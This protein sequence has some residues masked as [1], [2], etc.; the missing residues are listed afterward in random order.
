MVFVS[1]SHKH[2]GVAI[3]IF[4]AALAYGQRGN[5]SIEGRISDESN[6]FGLE[7]A[8]VTIDADP[9]TPGV[10]ALAEADAFGFY[11]LE[12]LLPGDYQLEFSHP[13]F[14]TLTISNFIVGEDDRTQNAALMPLDAGAPWFDVYIQVNSVVSGI[15]AEGVP[16]R[17]VFDPE[18]AP[19]ARTFTAVT[20]E[21]GCAAFRGVSNGEFQFFFN[22]A[23]A[24]AAAGVPVSP[25]FK[26]FASEPQMLTRPHTVSLFLEPEKDT[27]RFFVDW[28]LFVGSFNVNDPQ[29]AKNFTIKITGVDP[30]DPTRELLPTQ[31]GLTDENGEA[32]F[33]NLPKLAWRVEVSRIGFEMQEG[34]VIIMPEASGNLPDGIQVIRMRNDE[35]LWAQIGHDL[36]VPY[37]AGF[38]PSEFAGGS[39]L[40]PQARLVPHRGS[41]A[42]GLYDGDHEYLYT[43]NPLENEGVLR[44]TNNFIKFPPGRYDLVIDTFQR[45]EF[46]QDSDPS[47]GIF[48]EFLIG[49]SFRETFENLPGDGALITGEVE[50]EPATVTGRL[51]VRDQSS[52][53]NESEQSRYVKAN[54]R[55]IFEVHEIAKSKVKPAFH[56]IETT[57]NADGEFFVDL[58]PGIYGIILP[59]MQEGYWA[60]GI[61]VNGTDPFRP[62]AT[63]FGR[64]GWPLKDLYSPTADQST[65]SAYIL[66]DGLALSSGARFTI[67]LL[68]AEELYGIDGQVRVFPDPNSFA[69]VVRKGDDTVVQRFADLIEVGQAAVEVGNGQ[70]QPLETDGE[71]YLYSADDLPPGT[72]NPSLTTDRFRATD[73]PA[74]PFTLPDLPGPGNPPGGANFNY[75]DLVALPGDTISGDQA[76]IVGESTLTDESV[77]AT[78]LEWDQSL[79]DGEGGYRENSLSAQFYQVDYAGE[80]LFQ[81]SPIAGHWTRVWFQAFNQEIYAFNRG[82]TREIVL[83][84][85]GPRAKTNPDLL[86]EVTYTIAV[87]AVNA[88]FPPQQLAVSVSINGGPSATTPGQRSGLADLV[89]ST[90]LLD[91]SWS[92]ESAERS[93]NRGTPLNPRYETTLLL[94]RELTVAFNI[95]G[96][97]GNEIEIFRDFDFALYGP[98]G[99]FIG[100][101]DDRKFQ[102]EA[103]FENGEFSH[104]EIEV[105]YAPHFFEI[106]KQGFEP[107]RI[108]VPY[109]Q[110]GQVSGSAFFLDLEGITLTP[111][112]SPTVAGEVVFDKRGFFFA[113]LKNAG[114]IDVFDDAATQEALRLN[115][116]ATVEG[117]SK[118]LD[119]PSGFDENGA[120]IGPETRPFDDPVTEVWLIDR[121]IWSNGSWTLGGFATFELPDGNLERLAWLDDL[122]DSGD[123]A[124]S[125]GEPAG[126]DLRRQNVWFQRLTSEDLTG[127]DLSR[128]ADARFQLSDLPPGYF[129]PALVAVTESGAVLVHLPPQQGPSNADALFGIRLPDSFGLLLD[130][131]SL[132]ASAQLTAAE[133]EDIL[134]D[135]RFVALPE[136]EAE[137]TAE[138]DEAP[139][140]VNYRYA[141]GV[142]W[143][144]GIGVPGAGILSLSPGFLGGTFESDGT[145]S[146]DGDTGALGMEIGTS[147]IINDLSEGNVESKGKGRFDP[148]RYFPPLLKKFGVDYSIG[149]VIVDAR[150]LQT[151]TLANNELELQHKV[152]F[153]MNDIAMRMDLE[154]VTGKLPYVGPVLSGLSRTNALV[155]SGAVDAAVGLN[156]SRTWTTENPAR[157]VLVEPD[158]TIEENPGSS[159][160]TLISFEDP[161]PTTPRNHFL[162]GAE[163]DR[164]PADEFDLT[165]RFGVGMDIDIAGGQAGASARFNLTGL[166]GDSDDPRENS[167]RV[168]P[169]LSGDWP[170]VERITGRMTGTLDAYADLFVTS[171]EKSWEWELIRFDH[172]FSTDSLIEFVPMTITQRSTA[173][174]PATYLGAAPEILSGLTTQSKLAIPESNAA[175][176]IYTEGNPNGTTSIRLIERLDTTS[177]A[178]NGPIEIA[179]GAN[180]IAIDVVEH[181][182]G[183]WVVAWSEIEDADLDLA[184]PPSRVRAVIGDSSR[185]T[186][187]VPETIAELPRIA[188]E[189][190][191]GRASG[192]YSFVAWVLELD[193]FGELRAN[194]G[195][196]RYLNGEWRAPQENN[197]E[198]DVFDFETATGMASSDPAGIYFVDPFGLKDINEGS[199]FSSTTLA[200]AIAPFD[201]KRHLS[202]NSR[203]YVIVAGAANGG[204]SLARTNPIS[205]DVELSGTA[206]PDSAAEAIALEPYRDNDTQFFVAWAETTD[207][208][209][210][211]L[212][213]ALLNQSLID[214]SI[215]GVIIEDSP[216]TFVDLELASNNDATVTLYARTVDDNRRG[217]LRQFRLD[218]S[219]GLIDTDLDADSLPDAEELRI[220]DADPADSI[221][222]IADVTGSDDFD[223]DGVSNAAEIAAGTDPIDPT[224]SPGANIQGVGVV[225][226][227]AEA[228]EQG[229]SSGL[230]Q[231]QRTTADVNAALT[232]DFVV[233]GSAVEIS[234]FS[235]LSRSV[236]IPAGDVATTLEILPFADEDLEGPETV[237]VSIVASGNY[238]VIPAQSS[239]TITI[240]DLPFNNFRVEAYGPIDG[241]NDAISGL[242]AD[243]EKDGLPMLLE[244]AFA[245]DPAS[246]D[247]EGATQIILFED[248]TGEL[249]LGIEYR[250]SRNAP[251]VRHIVE[252]NHSFDTPWRSGPAYV[253]IVEREPGVDYDIVVARSLAP[254]GVNPDEAAFMRVKVV[255][256]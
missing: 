125:P 159:Q 154:P 37:Y 67:D 117:V 60:E 9:A 247:S 73:D 245:L 165:F 53:R 7:G 146:L 149:E 85:G 112:A 145:F 195:S 177:F 45:Y 140:H 181:W 225:A 251:E 132:I 92:V 107:L 120:R 70:F 47:D 199:N 128:S 156:A 166:D 230:L 143:S 190:S 173:N 211:N 18:G 68:V 121:R 256:E 171:L 186:W 16:V 3:A 24:A 176:A 167:V 196:A 219:Q 174:E 188:Q 193:G 108:E 194:L 208:G 81:G 100:D 99:G 71:L 115:W 12:S 236:T 168:V 104:Y 77:T 136:F 113:G 172:Q 216:V 97:I 8:V 43:L 51:L 248:D 169:N 118:T 75:R 109:T 59:D 114:D 147:Y 31:S 4:A 139:N 223:G 235:A 192:T 95:R 252:V 164:G 52:G 148:R 46:P 35:D 178:P 103:Q 162:G 182:T 57:T 30:R 40:S 6:Q 106:R 228:S 13:A 48:P 226:L 33:I 240:D 25:F 126:A 180:I 44:A 39:I 163:Y 205:N 210:H 32:F 54:E 34:E 56:Q 88:A 41:N 246:A 124:V 151:D 217:A 187:S 65:W 119:W 206:F 78:S 17:C 214:P 204:V 80:T 231:F 249:Y 213:F 161:I 116:Q 179:A 83:N 66:P 232:V 244:Y 133:L 27:L 94:Q 239:A 111:L 90:D 21:N 222:L 28:D 93:L 62:G 26:A 227:D 158:F 153:Q 221:A 234:D 23:D 14:T 110:A 135:G 242:L 63:D 131:V 79:N 101:G 55:I 20:D 241:A 202:D 49:M 84:E 218:A 200:S 87:D 98:D 134:P 141:F 198:R 10:A 36:E 250:E 224:D 69:L 137:I 209:T 175:F 72:Y 19:T 150:M 254:I 203:P 122:G 96:E 15:E 201:V 255:Y 220:I 91:T 29:I 238:Q 184:E 144:E 157:S 76:R 185:S 160:Y 105:P 82:E 22:D 207:A 38:I 11:R 129:R 89:R 50:V 86:P 191:A 183:E 42:E 102:P 2:L 152:S 243:S 253:E 130:T 64:L 74:G 212:R 138:G 61:V 170:P 5:A 58:P 233:T 197:I 127:D 155:I 123:S 229:P 1:L 215:S 142:N 237:I 189:I